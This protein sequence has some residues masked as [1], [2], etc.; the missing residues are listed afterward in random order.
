VLCGGVTTSLTRWPASTVAVRAAASM[1]TSPVSR[2]VVMMMPSVT[3][4]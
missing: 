1:T 4:T 3:L 2:D